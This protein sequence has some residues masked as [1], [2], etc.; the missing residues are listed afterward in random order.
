MK[1]TLRKA[2]AVQTAINEAI[3]ALDLDINVSVNE[4]EK[5][6]EKIAAA[7]TV[8]TEN[9]KTREVMLEALYNIRRDV[10]R[11]N[12]A[13]GI[14]DTLTQV[15]LLEKQIGHMTRLSK[16]KPRVAMEVLRGKLGKI[17]SRDPN[18]GDA[19]RFVSASD[20]E[21]STSIFEVDEIVEFRKKATD[22]KKRKLLLQ[23]TLLELNVKT[24][25]EVDAGSVPA[26]TAAG[27]L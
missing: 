23:D 17:S 14:N 1:I 5:P 26:L 12:A 19:Y 4:F 8:F 18:A 25:I 15:A 22:M 2:N 3:S 16:S 13:V 24:E 21:V 6:I 7:R 10:A 20:D 11:A 9:S 27:I